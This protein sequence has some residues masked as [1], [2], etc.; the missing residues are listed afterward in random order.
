[1]DT[2]AMF[3]SKEDRTAGAVNATIVGISTEVTR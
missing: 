2:N 3:V 1:M